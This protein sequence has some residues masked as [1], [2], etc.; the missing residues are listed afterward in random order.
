MT[1]NLS[2]IKLAMAPFSLKSGFAECLALTLF[3]SFHS[4]PKVWLRSILG[5]LA[6]GGGGGAIH[7]PIHF[8]G[9]KGGGGSPP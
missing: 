9:G 2:P 8:G 5:G 6:W 3:L 4:L 1:H 7:D